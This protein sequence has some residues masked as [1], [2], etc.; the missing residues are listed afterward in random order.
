MKRAILVELRILSLLETKVNNIDCLHL[1]NGQYVPKK[2][3]LSFEEANS[4][5]AKFI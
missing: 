2:L 3:R 4:C 5:G 1:S